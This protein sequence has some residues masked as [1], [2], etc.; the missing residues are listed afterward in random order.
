MF[1]PQHYHTVGTSYY[2]SSFNYL[3]Y[4]PYAVDGDG[5]VKPNIAFWV[6]RFSYASSKNTP[7]TPSGSTWR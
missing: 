1:N 3:G 2:Y 7:P 6:S 5:D 4:S